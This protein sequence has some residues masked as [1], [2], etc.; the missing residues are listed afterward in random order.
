MA[1]ID[2]P[3]ARAIAARSLRCLRAAMVLATGLL[4][5]P[6][7]GAQSFLG[8][9]AP[10]ALT[11]PGADEAA[12]PPRRA[13]G[14][15]PDGPEAGDVGDRLLHVL[16]PGRRQGIECHERLRDLPAAVRVH[17]DAGVG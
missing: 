15:S 4:L 5:A 6:Y 1:Q 9:G 7:A 14:P 8:R 10:H 17:L 16:Q 12:R 2:L 3:S 13:E 11:I